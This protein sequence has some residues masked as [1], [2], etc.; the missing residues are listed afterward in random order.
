MDIQPRTVLDE[1][2][3]V[4]NDHEFTVLVVAFNLEIREFE[5]M[6]LMI[7]SQNINEAI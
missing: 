1:K 6:V 5:D 7:K 4:E 2:S 3:F